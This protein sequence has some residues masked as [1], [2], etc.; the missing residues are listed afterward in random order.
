MTFLFLVPVGR[1]LLAAPSPL[2]EKHGVD[3][4]LHGHEHVYPYTMPLRFRPTDASH[5][6]PDHGAQRLVSGTFT[7]DRAFDGR[8]VTR[9]DG[10]LYITTGAGGKELYDPDLDDNPAKWFH[11]EDNNAAYNARFHFH[12][13]AHSLTVFD[14]DSPTLTQV[15][16]TGREINR[17]AVTKAAKA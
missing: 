9:P 4:W 1:G 7:P 14:V 17:I 8:H 6:T 5:A 12:S 2:F 10:I 13:S 11:A 16:E 15:D 3:F